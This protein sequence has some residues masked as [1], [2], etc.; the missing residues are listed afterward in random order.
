MNSS[1]KKAQGYLFLRNFNKIYLP[2]SIQNLIIRNFC[3]QKKLQLKL[4]INEHDI[5]NCWMELF[6]LIKKRETDIIIM[7][8]IYMLPNNKRDMSIFLKILKKNN[9]E[10]F[11]IFENIH[12]KTINDLKKNINKYNIYRKLNKFLS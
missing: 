3:E 5:K 9:K 10:F 11:F 1:N 4:S 12:T 2:T 8:S 6:S 7:M